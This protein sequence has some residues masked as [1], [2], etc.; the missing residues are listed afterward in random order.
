MIKSSAVL[1]ILTE[2]ALVGNK[3]CIPSSVS[4][5]IRATIDS[6]NLIPHRKAPLLCIASDYGKCRRVSEQHILSY[7]SDLPGEFVKLWFGHL[8]KWLYN[9][10]KLIC[11]SCIDVSFFCAVLCSICTCPHDARAG[12]ISWVPHTNVYR[13][14]DRW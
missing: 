4:I 5:C 13:L 1:R 12:K 2:M 3:S 6:L 7:V 10:K 9:S 11:D 14:V 8:E